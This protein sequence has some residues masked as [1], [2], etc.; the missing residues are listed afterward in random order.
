MELDIDILKPEL[1]MDRRI[2]PNLLDAE[3]VSQADLFS[4]WAERALWAKARQERYEFE[5][6]VTEARLQVR[7]RENPS[8]F[9]LNAVTDKAVHAA[10]KKHTEYVRMV[11]TYFDM[12]E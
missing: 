9:G 11:E 4:K 10:V 2:D 8:E 5:V 7:A 6:E 12:K 1:E 3:C